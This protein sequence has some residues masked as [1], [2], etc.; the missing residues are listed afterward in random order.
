MLHSL[1]NSFIYLLIVS[2]EAALYGFPYVI[3]SL[4]S[5]AFTLAFLL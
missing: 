2:I 3:S 5:D 1:N 4:V